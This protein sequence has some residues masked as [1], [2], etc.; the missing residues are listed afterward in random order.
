M[1]TSSSFW[2]DNAAQ[3]L[4]PFAV[5]TAAQWSNLTTT[6]QNPLTEADLKRLRSLGDAISLAEVDHIYLAVARLLSA[7]VETT[8][9]LYKMRAEML[10]NVR[11]RTPF[12][13]AIGGSVAVGKSTTARLIQQL[14]RDW[15]DAPRVD[16]ITTDGFLLPNTSLTEKGIM[17]RKGFPESYDRPTM[18][19]FLSDVKAGKK[20]VTA[21]VYSHLKYDIDPDQRAT[22]NQPDILIFEGLNVLQPPIFDKSGQSIPLA[23]DYFDFSIYVDAAEADIKRWY[24]NRF[25][26]LR[27]TAFNDP[28]SHFKHYASLSDAAAVER[29]IELWTTINAVNLRE[30]IRPTRPR[31]DLILRKGPNHLV[32]KIALRRL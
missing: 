7:H 30:N 3:T 31:A 32:E 4:S 18:L 15:P 11:A 2:A 26:T 6:A 14:L 24:I 22:L 25:L 5:F 1:S 27:Q 13:I 16:L 17:H 23:S 19:R 9:S 10:P 20:N 8:R 12:I 21:P 28:N 29:A